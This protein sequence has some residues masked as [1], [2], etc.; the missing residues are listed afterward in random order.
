[1]HSIESET[2]LIYAKDNYAF[3]QTDFHIVCLYIWMY[4]ELFHILLYSLIPFK[5]T[6]CDEKPAKVLTKTIV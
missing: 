6:A 2:L 3:L 4:Y 5:R 1:M